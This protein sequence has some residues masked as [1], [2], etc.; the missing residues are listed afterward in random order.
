MKQDQSNQPQHQETPW[1]GTA[2]HHRP[3]PDPLREIVEDSLE[4]RQHIEAEAQARLDKLE[5]E[6]DE[7]AT[8]VLGILGSGDCPA[9]DGTL[10]EFWRILDERTTIRYALLATLHQTELRLIDNLLGSGAAAEFPSGN[11]ILRI[12]NP[13]YHRSSA[14]A[15]LWQV[16]ITREV[17][18]ILKAYGIRIPGEEGR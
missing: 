3:D 7:R 6:A 13:V 17:A 9:P 15:T 18:S 12:L 10:A 1:V 14:M 5:D 16:T 4:L 2:R 8:D 11:D